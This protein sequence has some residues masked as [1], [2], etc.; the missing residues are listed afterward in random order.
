MKHSPIAGSG[1]VGRIRTTSSPRLPPLLLIPP[2]P[3]APVAP[4][5]PPVPCWSICARGVALSARWP[6]QL[7]PTCKSFPPHHHTHAPLALPCRSPPASPAPTCTTASPTPPTAAWRWR[8]RAPR[9][10]TQTPSRSWSCRPCWV[11]HLGPL[12]RGLPCRSSS[13][14][15]WPFPRQRSGIVCYFRANFATYEAS[16]P[17]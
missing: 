2:R 16:S 7:N 6:L 10:P 4:S 14:S 1:L 8:S 15:N 5:R 13:S 9:G 12:A 3:D 17:T 11:S